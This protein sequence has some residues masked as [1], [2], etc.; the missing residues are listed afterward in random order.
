MTDRPSEWMGVEAE[1]RVMADR[2]TRAGTR[3]TNE[4]REEAAEF[5][6]RAVAHGMLMA[7]E[8]YELDFRQ[9]CDVMRGKAGAVERG[10][11]DNYGAR[12][13][14]EQLQPPRFCEW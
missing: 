12:G 10:E 11:W 7:T 6:R 2:L 1:A 5:L 13:S 3:N 4:D 14:A 9:T 8:D